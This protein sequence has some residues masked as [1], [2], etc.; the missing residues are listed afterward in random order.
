[1]Y[2][3]PDDF[4]LRSSFASCWK[5]LWVFSHFPRRHRDGE[6]NIHYALNNFSFFFFYLE[7][8][9]VPLSPTLDMH[10]PRRRRCK[11]HQSIIGFSST[12]NEIRSN[13]KHSHD[14]FLVDKTRGNKTL[15][16]FFL[17][18]TPC[19]SDRCVR[20]NK[21]YQIQTILF[22]YIFLCDHNFF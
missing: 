17:A 14:L 12:S 1:M 2:R 19:S 13:L 22:L 4:Q 20:A 3:Q 6:S 16:F 15:T 10:T 8:V 18:H 21:T 7:A 9:A 11:P 5:S